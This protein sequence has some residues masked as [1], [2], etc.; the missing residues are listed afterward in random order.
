VTVVSIVVL[1]VVVVEPSQQR[2][3]IEGSTGTSRRL[4]WSRTLS[5]PESD[6]FF[7]NRTQ[8][9]SEWAAVQSKSTTITPPTIRMPRPYARRRQ[10]ATWGLAPRVAAAR[11]AA[12]SSF[13]TTSAADVDERA[14]EFAAFLR[15]L[16]DLE[17]RGYAP[18]YDRIARALA[19]E[20]ALLARI[21][22][23]APRRKLVPL[24]LF[25]AVHHLLLGERAHPLARIYATGLGDPWPPFR[26]L[27]TTRFAEVAALIATRSIQTN[28]V[29]RASAVWPALGMVAAGMGRPLALVEVGASAGL[30]LLLDRFA[31][32]MDGVTA[33]DSSATV[34]LSCR[35]LGS[36]RPPIPADPIA[37]ASR[38]GIDVA[39]VDVTSDDA[40]RWLEACVWPGL[41]PRAERLRAAI[42]LA[43]RTP[44]RV[45]AGDA[46]VVL[47]RVLADLP[48]DVTPCI[49][50]TWVLPYLSAEARA[51]LA[52]TAASASADRDVV[53]ITL[54]YAGIPPWLPASPPAP[55]EEPGASN[56][57]SLATWRDGA[58]ATR[59]LAWVHPHGAWLGWIDPT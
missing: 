28:E 48:P 14:R 50:S 29:G 32:D 40:C 53:W 42:A 33:G 16:A 21:V 44:P 59:T 2:P 36:H 43:R 39:P 55:L 31:Y 18:L 4:H 56:L 30:N 38:I 58:V 20:P 1:V 47:P 12:Y 54:E 5:A 34:R 49:V 15:G 41:T 35:L 46:T 52:S 9:T 17:L 10:I 25:A 6:P 3:S 27:V 13:V 7:L 24:L 57:L 8:T 45:L 37:I 11:D 19:D 22:D 51:S 26:E 23:A